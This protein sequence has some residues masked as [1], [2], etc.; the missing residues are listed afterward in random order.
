MLAE[1]ILP[2]PGSEGQ[3]VVAK[4]GHTPLRQRAPML[5]EGVDVATWRTEV[6]APRGGGGRPVRLDAEKH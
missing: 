4:Y 6:S 1:A 3:G 5:D 2:A